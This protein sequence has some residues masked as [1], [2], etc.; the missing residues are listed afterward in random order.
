M[1]AFISFHGGCSGQPAV[2]IAGKRHLLCTE[3]KE[4]ELHV[5]GLS[6]CLNRSALRRR[7]LSRRLWRLRV[8]W[9]IAEQL[10]HRNRSC[11]RKIMTVEELVRAID[12]NAAPRYSERPDVALAHALVFTNSRDFTQHSYVLWRD[13]PGRIPRN[14]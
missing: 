14:V 7:H 5:D 10:I 12:V 3:A 6:R 4:H 13:A 2:E 8:S 11:V 1:T 9:H